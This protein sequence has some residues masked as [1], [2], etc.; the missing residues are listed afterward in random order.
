M[1]RGRPDELSDVCYVMNTRRSD[2]DD[3][4]QFDYRKAD[5]AAMRRGR[6]RGLGPGKGT[7]VCPGAGRLTVQE[8]RRLRRMVAHLAETVLAKG[9]RLRAE[10]A[11]RRLGGEGRYLGRGCPGEEGG[12]RGGD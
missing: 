6:S 12:L 4:D 7:G 11:A 8:R 5:G 10:R 2:D 9:E 3:D 1:V